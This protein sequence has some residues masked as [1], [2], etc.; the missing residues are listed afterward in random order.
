MHIRIALKMYKYLVLV[1]INDALDLIYF[2]HHIRILIYQNSNLTASDLVRMIYWLFYVLYEL[3]IH[4]HQ[5]R[6]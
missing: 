6:Y 4:L 1:F 2:Y 3:K 5:L